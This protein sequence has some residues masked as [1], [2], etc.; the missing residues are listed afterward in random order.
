MA[1]VDDAT[2]EILVQPFKENDPGPHVLAVWAV[3]TD[4]G[5]DLEIGPFATT[6]RASLAELADVISPAVEA[7]FGAGAS[8]IQVRFE[9]A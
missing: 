8:S 7:G 1:R 5:L 4:A 6:V 3:L 2:A 9:A